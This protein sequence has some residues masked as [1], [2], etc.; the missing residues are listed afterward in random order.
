MTQPSL[1]GP[2][3]RPVANDFLTGNMQ[4]RLAEAFFRVL[5]REVNVATAYLT[6][7]GFMRLKEG[8]SG[9]S[10]VRLL[11]GE[12]PFLNRRGPEER[13]RQPTDD[14]DL[15][16][17]E[18]AID[19]HAFLEGDYPWILLTHARRKE[20]LEGKDSDPEA[21]APFNI[22]AWEK[23]RAL[24]QFLQRDG[25]EVPRRIRVHRRNGRDHRSLAHL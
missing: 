16:G 22:T 23:V 6:P 9:A 1:S 15:A 10:T 12:R 2:G 3:P 7:D 13:L 19:W 14:D 4:E 18:E 24:V 21:V 11:L 5:P 20:L 17:P 25:V 8:M